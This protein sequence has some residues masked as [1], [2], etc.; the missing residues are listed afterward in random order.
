MA[1]GS[2][3]PLIASILKS[4]KPLTVGLELAGAGGGGFVVVLLRKHLKKEEI[5][6]KVQEINTNEQYKA[7][8]EVK[9][10]DVSIDNEG[11]KVEDISQKDGMMS[12]DEVERL[13]SSN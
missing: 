6:K 9:L 4:I 7:L 11:L 2:N 5:E 12:I 10:Y 1:K 3:P 13:L 8:G